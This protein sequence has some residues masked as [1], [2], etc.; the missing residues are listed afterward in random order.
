MFVD[1][2]RGAVRRPLPRF[3]VLGLWLIALAL[4]WDLGAFLVGRLTS[5]FFLA[6]SWEPP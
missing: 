6:I 4:A 1:M 5:D 2:L 3:V